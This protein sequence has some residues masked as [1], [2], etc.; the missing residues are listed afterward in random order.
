LPPG[1]GPKV[2][3]RGNPVI[4][5]PP[6]IT[7]NGEINIGIDIGEVNFNS[8]KG[9]PTPDTPTAADTL[10]GEGALTGGGDN[11]FG[12]PPEGERWVGCLVTLTTTPVGLGIIPQSIPNDIYAEIVGNA[13]LRFN[14]GSSAGYDTPIQYRFK[15]LALWEPT[16]GM[17]PTGV[18]VNL[19]PGFAYQ[20][21][22]LSVPLE[23]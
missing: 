8:T 18:F 9:N 4:I 17:N 10:D 14:N 3:I 23:N 22:P 5:L 19:R 16:R 20:V 21:T 7:A 1:T 12:D 2:D 15:A 11:E 6:I 13:R